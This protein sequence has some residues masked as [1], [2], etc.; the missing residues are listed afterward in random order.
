MYTKRRTH[1]IK[2][3]PEEI[4]VGLEQGKS[5]REIATHL[6]RSPSLVSDPA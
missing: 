4:A 5:L 1:F 2:E 3:E 6:G